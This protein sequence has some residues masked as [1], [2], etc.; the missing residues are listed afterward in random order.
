MLHPGILYK[1]YTRMDF[2][3]KVH[4]KA[5]LRNTLDFPLLHMQTPLWCTICKV[6]IDV[7]LYKIHVHEH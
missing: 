3:K 2:M 1:K 4:S 7:L 5:L 6:H